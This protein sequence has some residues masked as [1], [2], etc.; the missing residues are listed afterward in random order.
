MKKFMLLAA[1]VVMSVV[2][3]ACSTAQQAD[4]SAKLAQLQTLVNNGCLVV[5]PTLTAVAALD[6]VV[7]TAATA[8]GLFC[9]TAGA[10]T[11]TSVQ[12]LVSTGIPAIERAI[13]ASTLVPAEQKPIIIAA[14]G[15]FQLTVGN[16]LAL[17]GNAATA[18]AASTSAVAS[19]SVAT[20]ASAPVAASE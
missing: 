3:G 10:I 2:L 11:V 7:A 17:Y 5:Q 13:T 19:A 14:L 12:S 16:A 18:T 8:N 6:P 9:A 15:V 4:A 1:G 20:A